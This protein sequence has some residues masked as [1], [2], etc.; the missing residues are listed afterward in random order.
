MPATKP[1]L[2]LDD[3]GMCN[4]CRSYEMRKEVDWDLHHKELL[5]VLNKYRRPD[6]R[7]NWA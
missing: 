1:D 4:A 7:G 6:D 2:Q 3:A 5:Q